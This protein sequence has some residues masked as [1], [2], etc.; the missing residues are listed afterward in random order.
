MATGPQEADLD[1]A[2]DPQLSISEE[3]NR[4]V[5]EA[6]DIEGVAE[7]IAVFQAASALAPYVEPPA[8]D[9]RFSTGAN[10]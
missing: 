5:R 7:A 9:F 10:L 2:E 1:S 3:R 8:P 6:Q 4:L